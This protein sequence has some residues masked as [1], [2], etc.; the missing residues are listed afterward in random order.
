MMICPVDKSD[1]DGCSAKGFGRRQA[2]EAS[3]DNHDSWFPGI[4]R[5]SRIAIIVRHIQGRFLFL[6]KILQ[7]GKTDLLPRFISTKT[8]RAF[9]AYLKLGPDGK[10]GFEFEPREKKAGRKPPKKKPGESEEAPPT[11]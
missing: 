7:T 8:K 10:V 2:T 3:S 9:A 11:E 1:L 6:L 4:G 5:V